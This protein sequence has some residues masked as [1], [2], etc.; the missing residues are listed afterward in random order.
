MLLLQPVQL[1]RLALLVEQI[2]D[3]QSEVRGGIAGRTGGSEEEAEAA[4]AS[5][6][7]P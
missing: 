7:D 3:V 6:K 4:S 5:S 2:G 1:Q